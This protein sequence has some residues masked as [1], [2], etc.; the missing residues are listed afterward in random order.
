VS[1]IDI[2]SP[3]ALTFDF[4][5]VMRLL[6]LRKWRVL[7]VGG[8]GF[9]LVLG[10]AFCL[11]NRF[12][13]EGN[14]VVR[15][16]A[17]VA[18]ETERS[19]NATAV[20]EA[21]VTT[22]QDILLSDRILRE[23]SKNL[24]IPQAQ[25]Y[26][27]S[28]T[29]RSILPISKWIDGIFPPHPITDAVWME[30]RVYFLEQAVTVVLTKSSS[31]I[32]VRAVARSPELAAAIVNNI[33]QSYMAERTGQEARAASI[34]E[35]AL[36]EQLR[37]TRQQIKVAE[38]D[39]VEQLHQPGA[40]E[41]SEVPGGSQQMALILGKLIEAR[42]D[43]ASREAEYQAAVEMQNHK[44]GP[45]GSSETIKHMRGELALTQARLDG[46]LQTTRPE[47]LTRLINERNSL[48]DQLSTEVK[49]DVAAKRAMVLATRFRILTL[50]Q[51]MQNELTARREQSTTAISIRGLQETVASLW[52]TS[53]TLENRLI[54]L[55]AHPTN[56]NAHILGLAPVPTRPSFPKHML[57]GVIGL[58]AGI[59]AMT[60]W[61]LFTTHMANRRMP[62]LEFAR[63]I[64]VPL[65][66]GL[67][68]IPR[69]RQRNGRLDG[70]TAT[71]LGALAMQLE[72]SINANEID[73]LMITSAHA[74]EG[75]TTVVNMLA[76][77][78]SSMSLRV[79][80][81]NLDLHKP[82]V[83]VANGRCLTKFQQTL[84]NGQVIKISVVDQD[85]PHIYH[86][87]EG[88]C[89][90]DPWQYLR[91]ASLRT[92]VDNVKLTYNLII[93]DTPPVMTF[94]DALAIARL[95]GM[96]ILVADSSQSSD[97]GEVQRRFG[98]Q[99]VAG[100]I[101]TK[102]NNSPG[103]FSGQYSKSYDF[104]IKS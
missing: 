91:S 87:F 93:F 49:R 24:D 95:T 15:S 90:H 28:E 1:Y 52:R 30:R 45:D 76:G 78:L 81:I 99:R 36:R 97:I 2:I 23:A 67:P 18:P 71:A 16:D 44:D 32:T 8:I 96:I 33:I 66:A 104:S 27:W 17:L 64:N 73:S 21:V 79:L 50:Q 13:A 68:E 53:D 70:P 101:V 19:F 5:S 82:Y 100:V 85:G 74:G 26:S 59:T 56:L 72:E 65:L 11:P 4:L 54:D 22:E 55:V 7:G 34:I 3:T 48:R 25:L 14:L 61:T 41:T 86:P 63:L 80:V 103:A 47:L 58:M 88:T 31:L 51:L 57:F 75:K 40:I 83:P 77:V 38:A 42:A 12:Q 94:P 9:A 62:A 92:L 89:C 10:I 69:I 35:Q 46:L 6:W 102:M 98:K 60:I 20:N 84:P 37:T 29:L 39:L 43:L